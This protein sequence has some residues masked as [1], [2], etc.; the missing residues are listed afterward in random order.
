MDR[1][2]HIA[3]TRSTYTCLP[4]CAGPRVPHGPRALHGLDRDDRAA[5]GAPRVAGRILQRTAFAEPLPLIAH[6]SLRCDPIVSRP[7]RQVPRR[8]V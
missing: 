3:R 4:A 6:P 5:P 7:C 2:T 8:W 1:L